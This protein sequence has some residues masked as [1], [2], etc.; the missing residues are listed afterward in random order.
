MFYS[1][2]LE[3]NFPLSVLLNFC[4]HKHSHKI[5][6]VCLNKLEYKGI[7]RTSNKNFNLILTR[8]SRLSRRKNSFIVVKFEI[9]F[10][11]SENIV[12]L[13]CISYK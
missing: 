7:L 6:L 1:E 13:S 9:A 5:V 11:R 8:C 4:Y 2:F 3:T 10:I 12:N